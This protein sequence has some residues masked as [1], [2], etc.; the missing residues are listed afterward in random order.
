VLAQRPDD[1]KAVVIE[2]LS[3][4]TRSTKPLVDF[5]RVRPTFRTVNG[6]QTPDLVAVE[7]EATVEEAMAANPRAAMGAQGLAGQ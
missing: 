1:S 2:R 6:A 3:V 4:Y 7:L 5:Y